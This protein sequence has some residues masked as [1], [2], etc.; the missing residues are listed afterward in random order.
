MEGSCP[1]RELRL[2]LL[3]RQGPLQG[4]KQGW[5]KISFAFNLPHSLTF[6]SQ[7][8]GRPTLYCSLSLR[9]GDVPAPLGSYEPVQTPNSPL[10]T[11]Y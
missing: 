10:T 3:G 5:V 8:L 7:L 11:L 4:F 6:S 9:P 2:Y 1:F